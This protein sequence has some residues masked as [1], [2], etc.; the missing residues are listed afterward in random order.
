MDS[1][2]IRVTPRD[3]FNEA[4]LLKCMGQ[5][6]LKVHDNMVPVA[7]EV[8][9]DGDPFEIAL[10]DEGALCISNL[11]VSIHGV[12]VVFQATYNSRASYPL[13]AF[14]DN[15]EYL[16]FGDDGEFTSEFIH[17]CHSLENSN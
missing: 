9:H 17:F 12:G 5:L 14:Y 7:M 16:V 11:H 8:T 1:S 4:K 15:C 2:Y 3:L 13:F 10:L 6:C